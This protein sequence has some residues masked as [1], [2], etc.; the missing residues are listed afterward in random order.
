MSE[1]VADCPRCGAKSITFDLLR[2]HLIGFQYGWQQWYEAFCICRH[3]KKSTVF[4]LSQNVDA[5]KEVVHKFGLQNLD[6]AVNRYM[7]ID[8]FVSLRDRAGVSPPEHVPKNIEA[9]FSEGATCHAVGCYNAAGTM[10]RLCIDLATRSMLPEAEH[11]GLNAK[12]R[13]DLGLRLP[14][15]FD[16]GQ[17]PEALRELSTCVKEDGNDG[18]HAGSLEKGDSDDLLDFTKVLLDRIYTEPERLRLAQARRDERR[19][20]LAGVPAAAPLAA[21][22][23]ID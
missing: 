14:W 20:P 4:V 21:K 3:C 9:A 23:R 18:A 15:M 5:D 10:F 1:L 19:K 6:A 8:R 16:N 2:E 12:T 13:R 11:E 7:N 17:L 22:K